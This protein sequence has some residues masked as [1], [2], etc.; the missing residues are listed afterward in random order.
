MAK[1]RNLHQRNELNGVLENKSNV[2]LFALLI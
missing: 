2:T 1:K